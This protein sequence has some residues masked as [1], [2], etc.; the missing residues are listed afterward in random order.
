[1]TTISDAFSEAYVLFSDIDLHKELTEDK[2]LVPDFMDKVESLFH[3]IVWEQL[4]KDVAEYICPV[5]TVSVDSS[6][7]TS[8]KIKK[9]TLI[10]GL[11]PDIR[12]STSFS[13]VNPRM[14]PYIP[15]DARKGLTPILDLELSEVQSHYE[16]LVRLNEVYYLHLAREGAQKVLDQLN[17]RLE[18]VG[19]LK[20]R[21]DH[22]NDPQLTAEALNGAIYQINEEEL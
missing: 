21:L 9:E 17:K 7:V 19:G 14:F 5:V 8:R 16:G 6:K 20:V 22:L 18:E 13:K 3:S 15:E 4:G 12:I 11:S 2:Y 10:K 1:M